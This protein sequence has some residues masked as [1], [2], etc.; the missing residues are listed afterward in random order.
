MGYGIAANIADFHLLF[1]LFLNVQIAKAA[2]VALVI[3]LLVF[4]LYRLAHSTLI[5]V[6]Y[7]VEGLLAVGTRVAALEC[8]VLDAL[9]AEAVRAPVEPGQLFV[10]LFK[11]DG[12]R[13]V[14]GHLV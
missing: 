9:E 4:Y 11:T 10:D 6:R 12:A 3:R 2:G 5:L 14:R 7:L 13:L 8:P 1:F